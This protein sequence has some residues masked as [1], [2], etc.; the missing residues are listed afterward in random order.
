LRK[1]IVAAI[2]KNGI[3]G[4]DGSIPWHSKDD[5]QYFKDLTTGFPVIMGRKTFESFKKPLKGRQNI[6]LTKREDV[7]YDNKEIIIFNDIQT[8][9]DYCRNVI[10]AEKA[11]IIGGA[12]IYRQT[13]DDADELSIS[14]FNFDAEGD[15]GFPDT[16]WNKWKEFRRTEYNGFDV[17]LYE[18]AEAEE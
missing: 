6:V 11:F 9:F 7:D 15:V 4:A 2:S 3:I 14:R 12:E 17:V 8:A 5:M 16:D 13:I 18:K 1:I 10:K